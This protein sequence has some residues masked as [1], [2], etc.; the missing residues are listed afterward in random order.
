[1]LSGYHAT[2]LCMGTA[3]VRGA[4]GA[5]VAS[6]V[7]PRAEVGSKNYPVSDRTARMNHSTRFWCVVCDRVKEHVYMEYHGIPVLECLRCGYIMRVLPGERRF[8]LAP[9]PWYREAGNAETR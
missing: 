6:A 4:G 1:V 8:P 7:S 2:C 5:T 9:A 3:I